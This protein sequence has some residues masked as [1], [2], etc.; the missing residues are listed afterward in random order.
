MYVQYVR[1]CIGSVETVGIQTCVRMYI[2]TW[3]ILRSCDVL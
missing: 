3:S 1:I 2:C